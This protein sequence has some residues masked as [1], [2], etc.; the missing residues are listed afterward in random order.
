MSGLPGVRAGFDVIAVVSIGND[1]MP[2]ALMSLYCQSYLSVC[3]SFCLYLS[4]SLSLCLCVSYLLVINSVHRRQ[5]AMYL[6]IVGA[7]LRRSATE[8]FVPVRGF[9]ARKAIE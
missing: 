8:I 9:N 5:M 7:A 3:I 1:D 6:S 2:I 4:L